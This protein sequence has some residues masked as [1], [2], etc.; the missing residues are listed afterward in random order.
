MVIL[1]HI[2]HLFLVFLLLTLKEKMFAGKK[3]TFE[4]KYCS[5]GNILFPVCEPLMYNTL[6]L[7]KENAIVSLMPL[8]IFRKHNW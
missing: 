4:A 6:F 3:H 5:T 2:S 7:R 1:E 8:K